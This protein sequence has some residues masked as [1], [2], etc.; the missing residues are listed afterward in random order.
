MDRIESL[1][2]DK[3]NNGFVSKFSIGEKVLLNLKDAVPITAFVR[4]VT[5][6]NAKV[7]Y[8]LFIKDSETTLYNVDSFFVQEVADYDK[9]FIEFDLDNFS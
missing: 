2:Q 8:S 3:E 4:A 1:H 7:R 5:F 6:T 9:E